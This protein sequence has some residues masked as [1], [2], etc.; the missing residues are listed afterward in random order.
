MSCI[1]LK[2]GGYILK[3]ELQI[4]GSGNRDFLGRTN[5]TCQQKR[6]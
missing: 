1:F 4:R 2:A 3:G 6:Q 5:K